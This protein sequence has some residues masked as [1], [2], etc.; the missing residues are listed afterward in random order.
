MDEDLLERFERQR[1]R[2]VALAA[3][4]LGSRAESEDAVQETWLRLR[5][6]EA[7][8]VAHLEGWLTTVNSRVCLDVLR[9]RAS[10]PEVPL[11][12]QDAAAADDPAADALRAA[13][14]GS[15][16][17]LVLDRLAPAERVAF[18]L[19]DLFGT[20]FAEVGAVLD[21]SAA[22]ARQLASRGRRRLRGGEP[23][24]PA[25]DARA[26]AVVDAFLAAAKGG[27][28]QTLLALLHPDVALTAD[29]T[30]AALG[31][32]PHA[33]GAAAV[34]QSF[35]GRARAAR[36]ALV[37]GRPGLVWSL[38]G[39]PKVA[40]AFTLAGDQVLGI[41][42]LADPE[43]LAAVAEAQAARARVRRDGHGD[44]AGD[45]DARAG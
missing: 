24:A 44:G 29:P 3:R 12:D 40:F 9:R 14:V 36:P 6:S 30:A 37:Q 1:P 38:R 25:R 18:V 45:G 11:D 16:L 4:M 19:H 10:R 23:A 26:R 31:V 2:L 32:A 13:A 8:E 34:A 39:E 28:L 17:V 15:G 33:A 22:A 43:V 7:E 35:A 41:A 27:D 21:C 20:P 42:Q 5:R